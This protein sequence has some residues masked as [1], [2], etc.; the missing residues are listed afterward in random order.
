VKYLVVSVYSKFPNGWVFG[1][2]ASGYQ[3]SVAG[4]LMRDC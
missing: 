2:A 1:I 4:S 3:V